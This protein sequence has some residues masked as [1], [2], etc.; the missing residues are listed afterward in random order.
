[1]FLFLF[2]FS[3]TDGYYYLNNYDILIYLYMSSQPDIMEGYQSKLIYNYYF[4]YRT[5]NLETVCVVTN[6]A[7]RHRGGV[8]RLV[9]LHLLLFT[10][11]VSP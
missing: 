7:F 5:V 1:M 10:L 3:G 4:I 8:Y 2:N 6:T 11:Q 9:Q